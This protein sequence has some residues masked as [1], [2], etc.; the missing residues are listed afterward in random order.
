MD[1]KVLS[2][3]PVTGVLSFGLQL[4]VVTGIEKLI[5]LVV[6]SL[7]SSPGSA[8]LDQTSGGG[9]PDLI[10][11][12]L[13]PT[14][15]SEIAAEVSRRITATQTEITRAQI[16]L[17]VPE[18]EKLRQIDIVAVAPGQNSDEVSVKIRIVNN[19]GRTRDVVL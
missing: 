13:D 11:Y 5:Q 4:K 9:L 1:I 8:L 18:E 19:L 10:G 6:L 12:N 7:F 3:D 15:I 14:D 17:D 16:G 2:V